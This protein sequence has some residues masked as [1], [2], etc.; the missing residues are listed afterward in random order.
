MVGVIL[1]LMGFG[2]I[3]GHIGILGT[4]SIYDKITEDEQED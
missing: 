4:G 1:T 3:V 2:L